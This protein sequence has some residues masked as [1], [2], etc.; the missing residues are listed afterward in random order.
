MKKIIRVLVLILMVVGLVVGLVVLKRSQDTR[1]KAAGEVIVINLDPADGTSLTEV[2]VGSTVPVRVLVSTDTQTSQSVGM[3]NVR[4][5]YTPSVFEIVRGSDIK[6]NKLLDGDDDCVDCTGGP[7]SDITINNSEGYVD[8]LLTAEGNEVVGSLQ[9]LFRINF[10]VK[11]LGSVMVEVDKDFDQFL[12]GGASGEEYTLTSDI[13]AT[14]SIGNT[15]TVTINPCDGAVDGT[16]CGRNRKCI[17]NT[18]VLCATSITCAV[19]FHGCASDEYNCRL[20]CCPDATTTVSPTPTIDNSCSTNSDCGWCGTVCK[21]KVV[22]ENCLTVP[23]PAGYECVCSGDGACVARLVVPTTEP[24]V[25]PTATPTQFP[26]FEWTLIPTNYSN[27]TCTNLCGEVRSGS[28]C[29]PRCSGDGHYNDQALSFQPNSYASGCDYIVPSSATGVYCCCSDF[30]S[31]ETPTIQPTNQPTTQ[32][33]TVPTN[34]PGAQ[35]VSFEVAMAGVRGYSKCLGDNTV[36]VVMLKG[37][38]RKEYKNIPLT[39]TSKTT[40]KGELVFRVNQLNVTDFGE[41]S[42]VAIFVKGLR[43]LQMK[44]GTNNQ[45]TVYNESGGQLSFDND[46]VLNFSGYVMLAGDVNRDG[47]VDGVDFVGVKARASTFEAIS[48]G[49]YSQYDLDG[50]CQVNNSDIIL[51]IQ[52]LNEKYDQMY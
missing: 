32:P 24:T 6:K 26:G 17:N 25:P 19:G 28:S 8:I 34:P 11:A 1:R 48:E 15:A 2:G 4:V 5:R 9:E 36:D 31:Y 18:C 46:T 51:L 52:A 14:Y 30:I 49:G 41:D 37:S 16:S 3:V 33:T 20:S 44:Y 39:S 21:K 50:S 38:N 29:Q 27:R 10:N 35:T 12:I 42:G 47:T 7:I 40:S 45:T 43:H 13:T 22:G 23:A